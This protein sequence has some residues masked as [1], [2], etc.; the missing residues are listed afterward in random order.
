MANVTNSQISFEA[1]KGYKTYANAQ[2]RGVEV[3]EMVRN[4]VGE[5]D[6]WRVR[7]VVI[8][9]EDGRFLPAFIVGDVISPGFF[10]S[11]TNV[12]CFN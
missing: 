3:A 5:K 8:A 1:V 6:A 2:K 12:C 10:I 11:L 4:W 7:F 9:K